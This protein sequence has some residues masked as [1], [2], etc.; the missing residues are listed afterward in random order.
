MFDFF[1]NHKRIAQIVLALI[2][3]PFA[4]FGVERYFS[5]IGGGDYV[6]KVG[7]YEIGPQEFTQALRDEQE[8][9]RSRAGAQFNPAIMEDPEVRAA[10][11]E[12]LIR[13]HLVISDALHSGLT[14]TDTQLQK[15]ITHFEQFQENGKFSRTRYEALLRNQNLT[16]LGFEARLRQDIVL[17]QFNDAFDTG[18]PPQTV[19]DRLIRLSEQQREV[20]LY[21]LLPDQYL[22]QIKIPEEDARKY[23]EAHRNEFQ[24]P[25]QVRADFVVLSADSLMSQVQVSAD[26]ISKYYNEHA[27]QF[28]SR[29]ASH[30]LISFPP[31]ASAEAKAQARAKAEQLY[32]EASKNPE[33]FAELAKAN[34]QDPGSAG[35]GGDLGF[36]SR[37]A[38]VKPLDEAVYQMKVGEIAGPVETTFGYHVIEV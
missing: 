38:M 21:L 23:Y 33:K 26:E 2:F 11:L 32:Q 4:L 37:G 18:F 36:I 15:I 3:L 28:E 34:S 8:K 12:N 24:I 31:N 17:Q 14:A 5:S 19:V 29:R 1:R 27:S 30:I 22:L 9:M 6:A 20:S 35:K 13:R 10:I 16:P 25:E 7:S